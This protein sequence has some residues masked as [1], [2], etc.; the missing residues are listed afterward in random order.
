MKRAAHD[1]AAEAPGAATA[2]PRPSSSG[3]SS[4][5]P[6]SSR[7]PRRCCATS[8]STPGCSTSRARALRR[9]GRAGVAG[10]DPALALR[11]PA[12]RRADQRPRLRRSRPA[13]ALHRRAPRRRGHRLPRP[14]VPRAH[15]H[16]RAGARRDQAHGGRV[17]RR[18]GGLPRAQ[19]D[20]RPSCRARYDTYTAQRDRLMERARIQRQWSETGVRA[21]G[22]DPDKASSTTAPSARRSRRGRCARPE[23][24][25]ERLEASRSRGGAGS[26]SCASA[27]AA[28]G[29]RDRAPGPRAAAA[30]QLHAR[31]DRPRAGLG[32]ARGA[33]RARTAAASHARRRADRPPA[34]RSPVRAGSARACGS[35]CSTRRG[36]ASTARRRCSRRSSSRA[37]SRL[38]D[39]RSLLAKFGLESDAVARHARSLSPGERTRASLALLMASDVN[40]LVL[41]EPT[42]HLDLPAIV[43][44]R[45][46]AGHL[47]GHAAD[48]HPRSPAAGGR[49]AGP[50]DR[51][52]RRV[53]GMSLIDVLP[54]EEASEDEVFEAFVEWTVE[55]GLT[56]Y[57]HQEEAALELVSGNNVILATPTG[58]GK[59]LVAIAAHFMAMAEGRVTFYTA[60]IK[61]LVSREVLRAVQRLRGQERRHDHGRRVGELRRPDHLLH[62]RDPRE[63]RAARGPHGRGRAGGDGRVPLLCRPPAR[64][65]RGRCRC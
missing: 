12:A 42:N 54:H 57:E 7:A 24:A 5:A 1:L 46:R 22:S 51:A 17:R 6:T 59:S 10:R 31:P 11:R 36:A 65:G 16:A 41:D 19:R 8:G 15:G 39:A 13:R 44:A 40:W 53:A 37:G 28:L 34:A 30:R 64:R 29:G 48:R 43:G 58:S 14:R 61:A 26:C 62:G 20:R 38:Q 56:L 2:T 45:D 4:A 52:R 49:R 21:K 32:R 33:R 25:I 35:G 9:P 60:P 23:K 3:W 27:A 55:Q 63:H 47:R 18:V 50:H